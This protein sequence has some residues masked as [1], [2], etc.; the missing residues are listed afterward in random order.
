MKFKA[1]CVSFNIVLFLSLLIVFLLPA[2]VFDGSALAEFWL[3]NW[4]LGVI[5]ALIVVCVNMVFASYWKTMGY[6]EREDWPGLAQ[7]LETEA[8]SK[9]RF[10]YRKMS[11]LCDALLLLGDGATVARLEDTL[12]AAKPAL[13]VRLGV[14]FTSAALVM[15][16]YARIRALS[17]DLGALKGAE[18]DW[19]SFHAAFASLLERDYGD[20]ALRFAGLAERAREPLVVAISGFV[21]ASVLPSKVSGDSKGLVAAGMAARDRILSKFGK[22]KWASFVDEAKSDM[23]VVVLGKIVDETTAWVF[24]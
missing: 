19:L 18:T 8:F 12:K 9:K 5:F 21:A 3:R 4:F 10:S 1:L 23:R 13:R 22:R 6:L 17:E 7:Y 16:D 2:F 15:R 20:A 11:L 14:R 24:A